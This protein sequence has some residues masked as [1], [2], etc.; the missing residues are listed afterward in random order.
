MKIVES[1]RKGK[2][3]EFCF[4]PE[5]ISSTVDLSVFE[6]QRVWMAVDRYAKDPGYPGLKL[7]RLEGRAG[8]KRLWSVRASQEL[9]ILMARQGSSTVFL[10]AGHHDAIYELADRSAFVSPMSGRPGLI[11]VS[12]SGTVLES[13]DTREP[14]RIVPVSPSAVQADR[15]SI[16]EHWANSDLLGAGFEQSEID[17]LRSVNADNLLDRWSNIE[18]ETLSRV[19][20]LS[21]VSPEEWRQRQFLGDEEVDNDRFR[22]TI[23][24]R[25]PLSGLSSVLTSDE[26][27]KLAAAPIEDWMIFLHPGQ[28]PIVDRRYNG[29]ARVRGSA[30]TGKT[31]VALHRAAALAKR[32]AAQDCDDTESHT[33]LWDSQGPTT[34]DLDGGDTELPNT[35]L[36]TTFVKHLPAL[37]EN[38]Y[39]RLPTVTRGAVE[40]IN[41]DKL[42]LRICREAGRN[43]ILDPRKVHSTFAKAWNAIVKPETP[44]HRAGLSKDYL[45]EEINAVMKGRGVD[46]LEEYLSMERTGRGTPFSP[47]MRQQAWD[48]RQEWDRQLT[49]A[50]VV[51]F[52]D[53]ILTA[54]DLANGRSSPMYRAAIVDESQ[55]LTLVGLQ[56]VRALV[57]APSDIDR[58]DGL[59]IVGDGA[60]K[61]YPGGFTMAQA[62]VDVRGNSSVLRV[63]YRNSR[64]IIAAAMACTGKE[65]IN[66]L[67]DEYTR[68]DAKSETLREGSKPIL[69]LS[70]DLDSQVVFVAEEIKRLCDGGAVQLGDVA[71]CGSTNKLVNL[72]MAGLKHS[73]VDCQKLADFE[74]RSNDLVKVG[75]FHRIKGLEFKIVFI[76]DLSAGRFPSPRFRGQT[77]SEHTDRRTLQISQL[78]VAMTRARDFLYV[79]CSK[80]PSNVI[81]GELESFE[82]VTG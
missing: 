22:R 8:R 26:V 4:D 78:F 5:F 7:E 62:G 16:L 68:G 19:L 45:R 2:Q 66:D 47:A 30:G 79:L 37:F 43:M 31:V 77:E 51:D 63:N 9:R 3:L 58:P 52:A 14:T 25:G 27:S 18:D 67:G 39:E 54:R 20:E 12:R 71:V 28:R 50:D 46:C 41:I 56:L 61:I 34:A 59:F 82:L 33:K 49:E 64:Q 42:A 48:L 65:K 21:E 53:V 73:G 17:I 35:I 38:L 11:K 80:N 10:R 40:F 6:T 36:F 1:I 76:L 74:G 24:E 72:A 70:E 69:V 29:A 60:Q 13:K 55:D 75:T 81:D 15:R 32:F 23:V 57:N 44:L